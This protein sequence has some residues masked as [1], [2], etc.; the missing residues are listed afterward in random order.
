MAWASVGTLGTGQSKTAA[1]TVALTTSAA[2][3][4]GNYVVV[5]VGIDNTATANAETSEVSS[6]SDSAGGNTWVKLAEWCNAMGSANAGAT[7]S[8]WGSVLTNQ[9][10][11]GGTIT[12][13]L[14]NSKTAKALTA[15]EFTIGSGSTVSV[16]S[17]T[18]GTS[19][20]AI[21]GQPSA[22]YL[23]LVGT[24]VE[25]SSAAFTPRSGW[26]GLSAIATTGGGGASNMGAYGQFLIETNTGQTAPYGVSAA[27]DDA[28][29]FLALKEAA[30][31][32]A[33]TS[34]SSTAAVGSVSPS[35]SIGVSG[36]SSTTAV[37]SVGP[38]RQLS[39]NAVSASVGAVVPSRQ[40]GAS[41]VASTA[42]AGTAGV[43][44]S[45]AISGVEAT[46]AVGT[47][48]VTTGQSVALTGVS[49]SGGVGSVAPAASLATTGVSGT[50]SA[51]TLAPTQSVPISGNAATGQSGTVIP[52]RQAGVSGVTGTASVGALAN[53]SAV[54]L[55]GLSTTAY[56]GVIMIAGTIVDGDSG[57]IIQARRRGRR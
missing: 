54:Q 24:A 45:A 27:G 29:V 9:I 34:N 15:W 20:A 49:V 18:V 36:V 17:Y 55:A 22:E 5:V 40:I 23:W 26:T 35:R 44:V 13:N 42:S 12:A 2:A 28:R 48:T 11:S 3:E 14:A 30:S 6:I 37:G 41:G 8:V 10:A 50:G 21:S 47:V 7:C 56:L 38:S 51:G 1:T 46:G 43:A 16:Q 31:G 52:I 57:W 25:A 39:G 19:P 32:T 4:A 53:Q 33:L